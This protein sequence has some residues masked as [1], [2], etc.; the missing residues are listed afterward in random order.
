M[1]F[2]SPGINTLTHCCTDGEKALR[3]VG[4]ASEAA[5]ALPHTDAFHLG[6]AQTGASRAGLS[7]SPVS[8]SMHHQGAVSPY[9][10][11]VTWNAD[12]DQGHR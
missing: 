3:E 4:G 6:V 9:S 10:V 12:A 11:G 5:L 8:T 2:D 1:R 7:Q